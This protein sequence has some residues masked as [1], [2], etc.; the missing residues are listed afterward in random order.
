MTQG[1]SLVVCI[2]WVNNE[3]LYQILVY[4]RCLEGIR[5][6]AYT[7]K[8]ATRMKLQTFGEGTLLFK[9]RL[10]ALFSS[11]HKGNVHFLK[12]LSWPTD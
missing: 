3:V 9:E 7:Y 8:L 6:E 10:V 2:G 5:M 1:C 12:L 4:A 11:L